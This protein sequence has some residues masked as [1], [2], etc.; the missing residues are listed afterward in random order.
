VVFARKRVKINLRFLM[1]LRDFIAAWGAACDLILRDLTT[2]VTVGPSPRFLTF[3][4]GRSVGRKS[5][6][7]A[8]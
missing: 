6:Q 4:G 5:L 2:F 8:G 3:S 1:V 7:W